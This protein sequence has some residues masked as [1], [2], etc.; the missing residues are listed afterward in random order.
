MNENK[1]TKAVD[2]FLK[3]VDN[4]LTID[5][6]VEYIENTL[7]FDVLFAGTPK[8]DKYIEKYGLRD[9][10]RGC[11]GK[12]SVFSQGTRKIKC[13]LIDDELAYRDKLIVLLHEL[14]HVIL[15]H[16]KEDLFYIQT[17]SEREL[18]AEAFTYFVICACENSL[19]VGAE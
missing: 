16:V 5:R 14:G 15:N 6:V 13:V 10:L 11:D 7:G 2:I 9:K 19:A 17:K 4:E 12:T 1:I 8:G 18:E 3:A